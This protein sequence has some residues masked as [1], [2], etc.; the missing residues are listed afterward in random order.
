MYDFFWNLPI[1]NP[2]GIVEIFGIYQAVI[3]TGLWNF[4]ESTKR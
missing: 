4:L 2:Y 1:L 3:P